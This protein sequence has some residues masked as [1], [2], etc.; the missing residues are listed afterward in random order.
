MRLKNA[1][2]GG[3]SRIRLP[4][5]KFF[6][7]TD[8]TTREKGQCCLSHCIS[9]QAFSA[10]PHL[11]EGTLAMHHPLTSSALLVATHS[12][13]PD[14]RIIISLCCLQEAALSLQPALALS[15]SVSFPTSTAHLLAPWKCSQT[16]PLPHSHASL[17]GSSYLPLPYLESKNSHED[18]PCSSFLASSSSPHHPKS[19]LISLAPH[20]SLTCPGRSGPL[21]H[22]K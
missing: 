18:S 1:S 20:Y 7:I 12:F 8:G 16:Y 21:L 10:K 3:K 17:V 15:S 14:N 9:L 6:L 13:L 5:G 11:P 4:Y 22:V 19:T 2:A